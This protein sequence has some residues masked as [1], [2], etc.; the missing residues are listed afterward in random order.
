MFERLQCEEV[1]S[2]KQQALNGRSGR[3]A[4]ITLHLHEHPLSDRERQF[5]SPGYRK[6]SPAIRV[7]SSALNLRLFR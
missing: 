6:E 7:W 1:R 2:P 4:D 5:A 3:E